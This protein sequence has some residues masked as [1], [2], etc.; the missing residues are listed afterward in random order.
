M[1]T[2]FQW[3]I[4]NELPIWMVEFVDRFVCVWPF[5]LIGYGYHLNQF[6]NHFGTWSINQNLHDL[7]EMLS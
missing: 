4:Y 1:E 7:T 6:L 5:N 3:Q 2:T